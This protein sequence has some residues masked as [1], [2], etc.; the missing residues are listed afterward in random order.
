MEKLSDIQCGIE[1]Y[2]DGENNRRLLKITGKMNHQHNDVFNRN[3][4]AVDDAGR[5]YVE[6]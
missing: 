5:F 2:D 6:W 1:F 3:H 4:I